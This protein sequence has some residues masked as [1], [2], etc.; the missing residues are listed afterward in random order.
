MAV[1]CV[2]LGRNGIAVCPMYTSRA[3]RMLY[4]KAYNNK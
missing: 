2:D 1:V 4:M 3:Q